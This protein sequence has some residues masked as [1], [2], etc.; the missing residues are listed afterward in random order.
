MP[1]ETQLDTWDFR[2]DI[3]NEVTGS[4]YTAGGVAV[5]VTVGSVDTTNNRVAVNLADLTPGWATATLSNVPGGWLY[6]DLGS[7]A[8]DELITYVEFTAP[9]SSTAGPFN[10]DFTAPLYV[11]A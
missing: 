5:T 8:A 10:V 2:N 4:G 7:A 9:V 6:K 1:S 11:N 3:T